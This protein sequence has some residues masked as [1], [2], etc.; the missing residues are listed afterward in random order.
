MNKRK[1]RVIA[2][3]GVSCLLIGIAY[4]CELISIIWD[5]CNVDYESLKYYEASA[6]N[7]TE[8]G[9]HNDGW[10]DPERPGGPA[11]DI[12]DW[13]STGEE[14]E[15]I[16]GKGDDTGDSYRNL[17]FL[18]AGFYDITVKG[19]DVN[20]V[21]GE[22]VHEGFL[23]FDTLLDMNG[24]A[25][26]DEE[27][28]GAYIAYNNDDDDKDGVADY[29]DY[30][31]ADEDDLV[32][33]DVNCL[34]DSEDLT[35]WVELRVDEDGPLN[36]KV[37]DSST[38]GN[39]VIPNGAEEDNYTAQLAIG[40]L[41]GELWVEG[42]GYGNGTDVLSLRY[43][44]NGT[45]FPGNLNAD[46][47]N[48]TTVIVD[49]SVDGV[50]ESEEESVGGYVPLGGV[51]R[52]V[53]N[54][55]KPVGDPP[56]QPPGGVP[57]DGS[58][59]MTLDLIDGDASK[60]RIWDNAER[61][62]TPWTL[63]LNF[64]S[65]I[66]WPYE[67]WVEGVEASDSVG[68]LTLGWEYS[69]GGRTVQDRIK[70]TAV[71]VDLDIVGV[72]DADEEDVGGYVSLNKDDD[73]DEGTADKDEEA[74][75][76]NED[77]LVKISLSLMPAFGHYDGKVRLEAPYG[78]E[79]IRVW[80]DADKGTLVLP[81]EA[82]GYDK[83]WYPDEFPAELYVEGY[84]YIGGTRDL[85]L[86][87]SDNYL[88]IPLSED[89]VKFRVVDI[90]PYTDGAI[91]L[92]DWPK[93]ATELRSPKYILG[94][95]DP[96]YVEVWNLGIDPDTAETFTDIVKVESDAGGVIELALKETGP[97]TNIFDNITAP[98]ELLY[99]SDVTASGPGDEIEMVDEEVLKFSLEIQPDSANYDSCYRVMVD[100]GEY[101]ACGITQYITNA[102]TFQSQ[103]TASRVNWW[104]AGYAEYAN[105]IGSYTPPCLMATFIKDAGIDTANN[106]EGD[107]LYLVT[108]GAAEPASLGLLLDGVTPYANSIMNGLGAP[109]S[110]DVSSDWNND[111]EWIWVHSC[112]QLGHDPS[113]IPERPWAFTLFGDP[114]PAHMILG[115]HGLAGG[116]L[117]DV[118]TDFFD[119]AVGSSP[120]GIVDAF[121]HAN[122]DWEEDEPCAILEHLANDGDYLKNPTRDTDDPE[123]RYYW[124]DTSGND[125]HYSDFT[126]VGSGAVQQYSVGQIEL[127]AHVPERV[128]VDLP[129]LEGELVSLKAEPDG[130]NHF[131]RVHGLEVFWKPIERDNIQPQS[132]HSAKAIAEV[133]A[134][135]IYE[136][137]SLGELPVEKVNTLYVKDFMWGEEADTSSG[138]PLL[139]DV[140][141]R[142]YHN[143]IPILGDV[144]SVAV[145]GD[146]VVKVR[147]CWHRII[148]NSASEKKEVVPMQET[149]PVAAQILDERLSSESQRELSLV[150]GDVC[151]YGFH[152]AGKERKTFRPVWSLKF[153]DEQNKEYRV[154]VDA[155]TNQAVDSEGEITRAKQKEAGQNR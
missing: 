13:T 74:T 134:S 50:A 93:T 132:E 128:Y 57:L 117:T 124:Y 138:V 79:H 7:K 24:V 52:V 150:G 64:S 100:R 85:T 148:E 123:M 151:Y 90:K 11:I 65:G 105:N 139:R 70:V 98:G 15:V 17:T 39:L 137:G 110:I 99:L 94:R 80:E 32:K 135:H 84:S 6:E 83:E 154:F 73:N 87:Y 12:W 67:V 27:E 95:G 81:T 48:V 35:G 2:I 126:H 136:E 112:R 16:E 145:K 130:L 47:I 103:M 86:I 92:D 152:D 149:L 44:P 68:D 61:T 22:A 9:A 25:D 96:I 42:C 129:H 72:A 60:I 147:A 46:I 55:V 1:V 144:V 45:W 76:T 75:V 62:G 116:N 122:T 66:T 40:D 63:P 88:G 127:S 71:E 43:T 115:Y 97:N 109:I 113:L 5:P 143:G 59:R 19:T 37:W 10:I 82:G 53:L 20:G 101:A 4:A 89:I 31:N 133:Q 51:K 49:M 146:E 106:R 29:E 36:I 14:P 108:H 104:E 78:Q 41:P 155:H 114:R 21:W 26:G 119:L 58:H 153:A 34:P 28:G 91:P 102:A 56:G 3:L 54:R 77:N 38:K 111:A 141:F 131:R 33:I 18:S 121:Y 8:F 120:V 23:V 142:H 140:S 69:I 30:D 118:I 107:I 125:W